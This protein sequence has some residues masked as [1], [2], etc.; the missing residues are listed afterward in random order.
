MHVD[1]EMVIERPSVWSS[2]GRRF[3]RQHQ[4][5]WPGPN[6]GL[7]TGKISTGGDA[8]ALIPKRWRLRITAADLSSPRLYRDRQSL[9]M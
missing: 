3:V 4:P 6:T 9:T 5:V 8:M 7:N 2:T 1:E